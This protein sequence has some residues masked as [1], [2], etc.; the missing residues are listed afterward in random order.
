MSASSQK[1]MSRESMFSQYIKMLRSDKKQVEYWRNQSLDRYTKE[2]AVA[3]ETLPGTDTIVEGEED[4]KNKE[5]KGEGG[6]AEE[7]QED[8]EEEDQDSEEVQLDEEEKVHEELERQFETEVMDHQRRLADTLA[9]YD[10]KINEI[11]TKIMS[12]SKNGDDEA[13]EEYYNRHVLLF[14]KQAAKDEKKREKA[15]EGEVQRKQLADDIYKAEQRMRR[16]AKYQSANHHR[17][18]NFMLKIDE[19]VPDY[20]RKNLDNMPHNKGYIWR[21]CY[22]FGKLPIPRNDNPNVVI[23]FEKKKYEMIIHET[24]YNVYK[25]IYRKDRQGKKHMIYDSTAP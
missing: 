20:I 7:N 25:K 12:A 23:M 5:D 3:L 6:E 22:Y 11:Q 17:E 18:F 4:R 9:R 8:G 13:F 14:E 10:T 16:E 24:E 15:L 1:A 19:S 21:G 2:K